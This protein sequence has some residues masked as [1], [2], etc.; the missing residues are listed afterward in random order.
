MR[1]IFLFLINVFTIIAFGQNLVMNPSFEIYS[2][3]PDNAFQIDYSTN[4][5]S[6]KESPDYFNS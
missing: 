5:Y 6:L 1:I 2:Q 4:W 3:C